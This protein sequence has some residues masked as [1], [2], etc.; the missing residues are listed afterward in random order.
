[1]ERALAD[2]DGNPVPG[3]QYLGSAAHVVL[4]RHD[5]RRDMTDS[6][7]DRPVRMLGLRGVHRLNVV[8]NDD[9]GH[10]PLGVGDAQRPVDEVSNLLGFGG[11]V[12]VLVRDVLEQ[13]QEVDLLLVAAPEGGTRLLADDREHR[14]V[15]EL[16][17]V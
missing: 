17:V 1:V 9:A 7:V 4:G 3:V 10:R 12:H 11:H 6:R 14:L 2:E 8:G 13:R 16:G 5:A 15:I